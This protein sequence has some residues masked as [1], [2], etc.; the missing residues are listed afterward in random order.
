MKRTLLLVFALLLL[1]VVTGCE[2]KDEPVDVS[3]SNTNTTS[4]DN[5][6]SGISSEIGPFNGTVIEK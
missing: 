2:A 4:A 1:V 6:E 3:S 5:S